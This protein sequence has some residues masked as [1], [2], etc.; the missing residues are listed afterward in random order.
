MAVTTVDS[1]SKALEFLGWHEEE[2]EEI[3]MCSNESS[4][5]PKSHEVYSSL[6]HLSENSCYLVVHLS[7]NSCVFFSFW[8][9]FSGSGSES[10]YYR[11]LYAW[12]D[13]L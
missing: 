13:R 4:L 1:G 7:E 5:S 9:Y 11:L 8:G 2:E 6:L 12:D 10:C 3:D